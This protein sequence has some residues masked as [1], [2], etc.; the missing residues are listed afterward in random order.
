MVFWNKLTAAAESS[1][2]QVPSSKEAPNLK[3]QTQIYV[4][5]F[6]VWSPAVLRMVFA[7][8]GIGGDALL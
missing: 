7:T 3:I 4:F 5:T 8:F 6:A 1:K 2:L